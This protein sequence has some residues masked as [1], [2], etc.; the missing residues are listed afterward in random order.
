MRRLLPVVVASLLAACSGSNSDTA[1]VQS[2]QLLSSASVTTTAPTAADYNKVVQQIYVAYFGRP[3][4]VGGLAWHANVLLAAK[5]PTDIAGI[6]A[7]YGTNA[8]LKAEIDSFGTSAES[9]ALYSGDNGQFIDALY[10]NLFGRAPDQAGKDYW[11]NTLNK[12]LMTRASAAI[13]LLGGAQSTDAT[14]IS[15]KTTAASTFTSLIAT[16]VQQQ[17]YNGLD[18]NAVVR[19]M[20]GGVGADTNMAAFTGSIKS[21]ISTLTTSA[22]K[23]NGWDIT[24]TAPA[25]NSVSGRNVN[26]L[27]TQV[28]ATQQ[29]GNAAP[30]V[31]SALSTPPAG[32]NLKLWIYDPRSASGAAMNT[33]IFIQNLS[34]NSGWTF[35][36][37]NADGSVYQNLQPGNYQFDTTEPN[38]MSNIFSRH[39]YQVGVT[40]GAVTI[41]GL[42]ASTQGYFA[43][44]LDLAIVAGTPQAQKLQDDLKALANLP[45]S[46]FKPTSMCQLQDQVT[47]NRSFSTDLSAGFPKVRI[48]L[49]SYGHLRALIVPVD[50][51]DVGGKDDPAT[52]FTPLANSMRDFYL[53][54][55]Y[56]R[57]AFDFDVVPNWVHLP[58]SPSKYSF[59]S[60]N[61]SGDF[62]SYRAAI[63][64][65]TEKQI[66]YSKYDA[67]YFLVPKEM[68][69]SQMGYGPAIT[70]PTWTSTGYVVNG[71][72]GGADMY[73]NESHNVV[74]AQWKWMAHETGHAFGLYDEDLNHA[75]QTLGYWSIM[76]MNWSNHA[77]E[78]NGWDRYLQGWLPEEQIACLPKTGLDSKGTSVVL[79]SLVRQ[80][81]DVKAAMVPLSA[82]KILVMES[83]RNE[84]YD[85]IAVGREGVLVYTVDMTLGTLAG[86]YRAQRRPGSVDPNF[87]D[88][89]LHVGD[90]ITVDGVTV[91]VTASNLDGD[92]VK[93]S[94]Q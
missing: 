33:G 16:P 25:I 81:A 74:G 77:I 13:Q 79:S 92:T 62:T 30:P 86:G 3:A 18:A 22:A 72:T 19:T 10:R 29:N 36:A 59:T 28:I 63:I 44:T 52:F 49:P 68:P 31:P 15:N 51:P 94:T 2:T 45:V 69:M 12:N 41:Q 89:A 35:V 50:F 11:V 21:T 70:T 65:M 24:P 84:G 8:A 78:H 48:R 54:Q 27:A 23:A 53:K 39:R 87:E 61:G 83:R 1:P 91:S 82:S 64:A 4:D 7:A 93:V 6:V 88:A 55:S 14:I 32:T 56:G 38:G 9:A 34:T 46:A 20:L 76:A 5:A 42:Q 90:T 67:V 43:V 75:S 80:T 58:F 57:L 73:Y 26:V 37:A 71:A 60:E 66:D 85:Q 47:P 17:G 40:S